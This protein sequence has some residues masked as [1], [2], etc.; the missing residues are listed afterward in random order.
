MLKETKFFDVE[1]AYGCAYDLKQLRR[2]LKEVIGK[3][4]ADVKVVHQGL[5]HRTVRAIVELHDHTEV[6]F[7]G[8]QLDILDDKGVI[9]IEVAADG[10]SKSMQMDQETVAPTTIPVNIIPPSAV[11]VTIEVIKQPAA[12]SRRT[13][14]PPR[15]RPAAA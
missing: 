11:P 5:R 10:S 4:V 9:L 2:I 13:S 1:C 12:T 14:R 6:N 7:E 15:R 3:R 8:I